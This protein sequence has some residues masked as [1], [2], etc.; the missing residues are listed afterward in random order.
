MCNKVFLVFTSSSKPNAHINLLI[1]WILF[2][3]LSIISFDEAKC[4]RRER[5]REKKLFDEIAS[6]SNNT[7]EDDEDDAYS[8]KEEK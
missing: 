8:V 7:K 1:L 4:G 2:L 3:Y 6:P 5:E